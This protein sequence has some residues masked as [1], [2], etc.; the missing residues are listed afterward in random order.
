MADE[1]EVGHLHLEVVYTVSTPRVR[2][3]HATV[4]AAYTVSTPRVRAG[5]SHVE[6]IFTAEVLLQLVQLSVL[7]LHAHTGSAEL[8]VVQLAVQTLHSS[9]PVTF[10]SIVPILLPNMGPS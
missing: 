4:E 1:N 7:T 9:A 8:Q 2:A 6:V 5:H 3:G 10:E